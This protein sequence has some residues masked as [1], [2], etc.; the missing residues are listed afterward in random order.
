MKRFKH[1][2]IGL[3][4]LQCVLAIGL[5]VHSHTDNAYQSERPLLA[6]ESSKV[7]KLRIQQIDSSIDLVKKEGE[8]KLTGDE[9]L[10]A[11]ADKVTD[12]LDKL[13]GI[14]TT[15]PIAT[16]SASHERFELME[17]KHQRRLT[18]FSGDDVVGDIFIGTSPGFR[19][20]HARVNNQD[21]VFAISMNA[22]EVPSQKEA[23]L[24]KTLLAISDA[25]EI[26]HPDY[27]LKKEGDVWQL[28]DI[29]I[30]EDKE[31]VS[32]LAVDVAKTLNNLKVSKV[33]DDTLEETE[34]LTLT[35]SANSE[36]SYSLQ[37]KDDKYLIT[38]N[39]INAVFSI[40]KKDYEKLAEVSLDDMLVAKNGNNKEE[41]LADSS[42]E[43][44]EVTERD[45]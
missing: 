23:W 22:Y 12:I 28:K 38:R 36:Y 16:T 1:Q 6:F 32:A 8:W 43:E 33:V 15:W 44:P 10:P 34:K 4:A 19:K 31:F 20:V 41:S 17:D 9:L 7:D 37:K 40:A 11:K 13:N 24:D 3:F 45:S 26:T 25:T 18:L 35:V 42:E 2:L 14:T 21:E 29:N 39:D 27:T 30:P 5:F